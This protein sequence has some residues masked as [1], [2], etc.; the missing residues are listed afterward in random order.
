MLTLVKVKREADEIGFETMYKANINPQG[1]IDFFATLEASDGMEE[2]IITSIPTWM[3]SHPKHQSESNTSRTFK[4]LS[5]KR[6]Y[7]FGYRFRSTSKCHPISIKTN[8]KK[9]QM[10]PLASRLR[11]TKIEDFL[12]QVHILD[13]SK[14]F[15]RSL[16]QNQ[17][18]STI[19][20]GP[21]RMWK[22]DFGSSHGQ[23]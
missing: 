21:H 1:M 8:L 7:P 20:W 23:V 19:F 14:P 16:E 17:I 18:S 6:V 2:E 9:K 13:P 5:L 11:P 12:G 22:N 3:Q 4:I 15:R 10:E